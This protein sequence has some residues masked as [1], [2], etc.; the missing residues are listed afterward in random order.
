MAYASQSSLRYWWAPACRGPWVTI[1]LYGSGRV[2]VRPAI[3]DAVKA[4]NKILSAY[5]YTTRY[6]DTGAYNCRR[7]TG[8]STYS[9][10]A[11]GIAMDINWQSNPYSSV[12]RTDM[13]RYGDGR[14]PYRFEAIRTNNGKQ[15]WRWGGW[16]SGN[17]D[18]MHLEITCSPSDLRT[19]INWS[20]VYGGSTSVAPPA[21]VS[22]PIGG[23]VYRIYWFRGEPKA[24]GDQPNITAAFRCLCAYAE[25]DKTWLVHEAEWIATEAELKIWRDRGL[26]EMNSGLNPITEL[27]GSIRWIKSPFHNT[28]TW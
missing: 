15:V 16:F 7:V 11:Y 24:A 9:L 8:G 17:K 12:L 21:S 27:R 5:R 20:T 2:T 14:M 18:A 25:D 1:S 13:F 23:P 28:T 19:G 10:H 4:I 3:T 26:R 22:A 6:A